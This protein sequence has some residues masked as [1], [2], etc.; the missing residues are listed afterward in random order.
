V[1]VKLVGLPDPIHSRSSNAINLLL[2]KRKKFWG[3][4][5]QF[6]HGTLKETYLNLEIYHKHMKC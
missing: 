1:D 6:I 2:K 3:T 4:Q 5:T